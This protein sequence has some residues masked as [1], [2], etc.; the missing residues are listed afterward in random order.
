MLTNILI[1]AFFVTAYLVIFSIAWN[2]A[3]DEDNLS[4]EERDAALMDFYHP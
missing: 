4:D 3:P 1:I 2:Q